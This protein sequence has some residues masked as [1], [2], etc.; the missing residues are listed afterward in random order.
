MMPIE[1]PVVNETEK[2]LVLH[3]SSRRLVKAAPAPAPIP[4]GFEFDLLDSLQRHWKLA[5]IVFLAIAIGGC[6]W[7]FMTNRPIYRAETTIYVPPDLAKDS[8]DGVSSLYA[9]FVNQQI[10]TILHYDTLSEALQRLE[11]A[12]V[13]L[14]RVG[15]TE[16]QAVD[17]LRNDLQVQRIPD[18][19]E[20]SIQTANGDTNKAAE[21]T[22]AVAQSFL[23]GGTHPNDRSTALALEKDSLE[24]ELQAKLE[25][26]AK[27]AKSLQVVNLQ[28]GTALPDDDVLIQMRHALAAAR[29][30]RIEAEEQMKA[31]HETVN[32]DAEELASSD[33]STRAMTM[34]L[35]QKQFELREKIRTMTPS[36]PVR[37]Q[38]EA[39]L[40]AIDAQL[41]KGSSEQV[42]KVSAQLMAKLRATADQARRVETD[43][44]QEIDQEMLS[45]PGNSKNMEM[46]G[47]LD[48]EIARVQDFVTRIDGQLEEIRL[49]NAAGSGMRVFSLASPSPQPIKSQRSKALIVVFA[50]ATLLS[51]AL[52]LA[53]DGLDSRIHDPS[54]VERILGFT[55]IGMTIERNSKTEKF[56]DEHLRRLVAGIERGIAKGAGSILLAGLKKPVPSAILRDIALQLSAHHIDVTLPEGHHKLESELQAISLS[57][58]LTP[59]DSPISRRLEGRNVM[60]MDAPALVFSAEAEHLATQADITLI[61]VQAGQDK[62]SDLIRGAR[63]LE[64]LNVPAVGAVLCGV[65]VKRAGRAL[66]RD[67]DEYQAVERQIPA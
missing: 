67:L 59:P 62:R 21:I 47:M 49:R 42:P 1:T 43:L 34:N 39:E 55:I 26:R 46:A 45:I 5:I 54:T 37:Q 64:R 2:A 28:K 33:P 4:H 38:A 48:T 23:D 63:L 29:S 61:V 53:L 27:L 58:I 9:T 56:A 22:N 66:R 8:G 24:K 11:K 20:I 15:Q 10:M 65:R 25:Q 52:P 41:N 30:R 36:H 57:K 16:Q 14:K 7:A 13:S 3:S 6:Q 51:L 60:L 40:A 32:A 18:S 35:L 44:K 19:Y 12:G 31:G 17:N 50:L